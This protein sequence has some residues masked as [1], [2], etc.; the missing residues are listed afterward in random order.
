MYEASDCGKG[1]C[2]HA[3]G[4]GVV[5]V[6]VA[7]PGSRVQESFLDGLAQ[8]RHTQSWEHE[9]GLTAQAG[10]APCFQ[11]LFVPYFGC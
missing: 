2:G 8:S 7:Q 9:F 1:R 5:A 10:L 6:S 4:R 3:R 11:I